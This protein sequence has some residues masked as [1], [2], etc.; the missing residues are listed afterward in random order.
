LTA[1]TSLDLGKVLVK[2]IG[3]L[4]T[5]ESSI[6]ISPDAAKY[7][8]NIANGDARRLLTVLEI[9]SIIEPKITIEVAQ[10]VSPDKYLGLSDDLHYDYLS[11]IQGS[12]QASDA[13]SA[14]YWLAKA[15]ESCLDPRIIG[16]RL[17]V[18]AAEDAFSNPLCTPVAHA[19]FISTQ[20]IGRP[21]CDI[22]LS[23]AAI[24]IAQ[25]PRDKTAANAIWAAVRD[26]KMG[27]NIQVPNNLRDCHYAGAKELGHGGYRDGKNQELYVPTGI[28]YI[29]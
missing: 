26:I 2:G 1:L 24:M 16:R 25:S 18:S 6:T 9:A 10:Q 23:Q 13:D 22:L 3:Y 20:T 12:I 28:K 5:E 7:I 19:A 8:I 15:L 21:E 29:K 27:K 14:V 11:A 17:L 4:R